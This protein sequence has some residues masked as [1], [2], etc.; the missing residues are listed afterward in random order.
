MRRIIEKVGVVLLT[1]AVLLGCDARFQPDRPQDVTLGPP[2]EARKDH[3]ES[4][5]R[6]GGDSAVNEAVKALKE[7]REN[8]AKLEELQE[9]YRKQ[10]ETSG[11]L[12]NQVGKLKI[13]LAR[14]ERELTEANMMLMALQK[15]LKEWKINVLGF[16][17]EMR[18]SQKVLLEAVTRLYDLISGRVGMDD[19]APQAPPAPTAARAE[20][21][22]GETVQ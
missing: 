14:A 19:K 21:K 9:K 6:G 20:E 8:L 5:I 3:R 17:D 2:A 10:T 18:R 11:E 13:E 4:V 15:E 12:R 7:W 22:T 1:G 16:R